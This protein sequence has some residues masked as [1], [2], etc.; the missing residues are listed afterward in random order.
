MACVFEFWYFL[1]REWFSPYAKRSV[2]VESFVVSVVDGLVVH[3]YCIL[4]ENYTSILSLIVV[5][6]SL[7]FDPTHVNLLKGVEC[8]GS[9]NI[10][11]ILLLCFLVVGVHVLQYFDS[12]RSHRFV[13][14]FVDLLQHLWPGFEEGD[15]TGKVFLD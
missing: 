6:V 15:E 10:Y 2:F 1:P 9:E 11:L 5:E 3:M 14:Y 7:Q 13:H 12:G 4:Y 8:L